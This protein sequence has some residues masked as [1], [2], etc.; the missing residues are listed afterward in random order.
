MVALGPRHH[1]EATHIVFI[2]LDFL[3]VKPPK[4][5]KTGRDP[6]AAKWAR[7]EPVLLDDWV[8]DTAASV[9][10]LLLRSQRLFVPY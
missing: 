6:G 1:T 3:A 7:P 4:N 5:S 8:Q 9:S 10:Q 2:V